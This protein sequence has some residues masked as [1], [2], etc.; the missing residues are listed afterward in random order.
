MEATRS[1]LRTR[2][3][4]R[5]CS[6]KM[7]MIAWQKKKEN[8]ICRER[9]E[10][11]S[12]WKVEHSGKRVSKS[13]AAQI[14]RKWNKVRHSNCMRFFSSFPSAIHSFTMMMYLKERR[15]FFSHSNPVRTLLDVAHFDV[16]LFGAKWWHRQNKKHEFFS[17]LVHCFALPSELLW[18]NFFSLLFRSYLRCSDRK[19]RVWEKKREGKKSKWKNLEAEMMFGLPE[20]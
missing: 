19:K 17:S 4:Y 8:R 1:M 5:V 20:P 2:A 12:E 11:K 3:V 16:E 9:E 15:C 18:D 7:L 10:K 6:V 14:T 13:T